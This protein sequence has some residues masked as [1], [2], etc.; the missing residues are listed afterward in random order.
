MSIWATHIKSTQ[1]YY[2]YLGGGSYEF[3]VHAYIECNGWNAEQI[4]PSFDISNSSGI[5]IYSDILTFTDSSELLIKKRDNCTGLVLFSECFKQVNFKF[6]VNGLTDP[7]GYVASVYNCSREVLDNI[8]TDGLT[9]CAYNPIVVSP[10]DASGNFNSAPPLDNVPNPFICIG[11]TFNL[12]LGSIDPDGDSLAYRLCEVYIENSVPATYN[13]GYSAS[14]PLGQNNDFTIDEQTGLVTCIANELG[15]YVVGVCI[16]EFRD[17]QLINTTTQDLKFVTL[18]DCPT[19]TAGS[20]V[21]GLD[22]GTNCGNEV[23][24]QNASK[25][26]NAY[27][28]DFGINGVSSDISTEYEP[29]FSYPKEGDYTV[30]FMVFDTILG[31]SDTFVADINIETPTS[32]FTFDVSCLNDPVVFNDSSEGAYGGS[33]SLRE[34]YFGD[35]DY[36]QSSNINEV[37]SHKYDQA[38]NW[39]VT[40]ISHDA[41]GCGTDTVSKTIVVPKT[42]LAK[43][44]L[45][46]ENVSPPGLDILINNESK[47]YSSL[48]WSFDGNIYTDETLDK[49]PVELPTGDYLFT[50][51]AFD[52][53]DPNCHG[54]DTVLYKISNSAFDIPTSFTPNGDG[55]ND[56]LSFIAIEVVDFYLVIYNRWGEKMYET[57]DINATG[58][59]GTYKGKMMPTGAYTFEARA[60]N[61]DTG[62]P[63]DTKKGTILL[64]R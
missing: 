32:N 26:G 21:S 28:W 58:W 14:Q 48:E 59:D 5:N 31:C 8:V 16:D 41:N 44:T 61:E 56:V 6:T 1:I 57:T 40:M 29:T 10:Q 42:A 47:Y 25:G 62:V 34:Y 37:I 38:D 46:P 36:E 4:A 55:V 35:G 50:L 3:T 43:F 15:T 39:K 51:I 19:F 60:T 7:A 54:Y 20:P 23:T 53:N 27:L 9:E 45:N 30:T 2:T 52:P 64:I 24:F 18:Q 63:F 11:D 13:P 17:G 49:V 33:V 12:M 22:Y